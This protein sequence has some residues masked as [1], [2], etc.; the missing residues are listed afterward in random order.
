MPHFHHDPY[1]LHHLGFLLQREHF[2]MLEEIPPL[3]MVPY[4]IP[5]PYIWCWEGSREPL[6]RSGSMHQL[7]VPTVMETIDELKVKELADDYDDEYGPRWNAFA[8]LY[9]SAFDPVYQYFGVSQEE[10]DD[11]IPWNPMRLHACWPITDEQAN[12]VVSATYSRFEGGPWPILERY[13][14]LTEQYGTAEAAFEMAARSIPQDLPEQRKKWE[15]QQAEQMLEEAI[16]IEDY[17]RMI[18]GPDNE[19]LIKDEDFAVELPEDLAACWKLL[20]HARQRAMSALPRLIPSSSDLRTE[21][22]F[23]SWP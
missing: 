12:A 15:Q 9:G 17:E 1:E 7:V 3:V 23:Y 18:Y 5:D 20:L 22:L 6:G 4:T 19:V 10:F 8:S 13:A 2:A 16:E 21:R 14:Q 11:T